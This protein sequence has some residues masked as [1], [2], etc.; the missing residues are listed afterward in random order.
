M[1]SYLK[2]AKPDYLHLDA[3]E[4][5]HYAD[6]EKSV[7]VIAGRF[8]GING[9]I[10]NHNVEPVYFDVSLTKGNKFTFPLC[11]KKIVLSICMMVKLRWIKTTGG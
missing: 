8:E 4:I 11:Q 10:S 7:K 1:P 6:P 2:M 9:A 5:S 3:K